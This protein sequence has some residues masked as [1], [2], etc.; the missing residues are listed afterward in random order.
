[1][2]CYEAIDLMADALEG[3]LDAGVRPGF[4]EHLG[5]CPPCR[6]YHQQLGATLKTI[7]RLPGTKETSPHR[8][9]LIDRF[10]KERRTPRS[11]A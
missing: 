10:R 6:T 2:N 11:D 7:E 9:E 5:E 4:E 8:S 3:H 1:M